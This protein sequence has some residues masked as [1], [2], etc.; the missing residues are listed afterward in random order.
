MSCPFFFLV[1]TKRPVSRGQL[2][3]ETSQELTVSDAHEKEV[4]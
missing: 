2:R 1:P 3:A 4:T